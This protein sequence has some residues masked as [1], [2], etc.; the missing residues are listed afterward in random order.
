MTNELKKEMRYCPKCQK[1]ET[2]SECAYGPSYWDNY[3][4]PVKQEDAPANSA[5]IGAVDGIGVGPN[6]EPGVN[7]KKKLTPFMSFIKRSPK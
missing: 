2:R 6:G 7:K 3:A 5:G 4:E 1:M